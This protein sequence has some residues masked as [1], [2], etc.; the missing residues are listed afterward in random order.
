MYNK[1]KLYHFICLQTPIEFD[2]DPI[3]QL[4]TNI[5]EVE[6]LYDNYPK[7]S[8][9]L[10]YFAR[11]RI[12]KIF[13]EN[14][15]VF[16]IDKKDLSLKLS[17][18]KIDLSELFY[19]QLLIKDEP[20]II[21][22]KYSIDYIKEINNKIFK[23]SKE[24][25]IQDFIA[26]KL[27]LDLIYNYQNDDDNEYD[28]ENE[29]KL[30]DL[31]EKNINILK[32]NLDQNDVIKDLKYDS[33]DDVLEKP[34]DEI[35]VD[36]IN[37]LIKNNYFSDFSKTNKILEKL[38]FETINNTKV[39]HKGIIQAL[40][41]N[42]N[43]LTNYMI[44]ESNDLTEEKV[45]F[46]YFLLKYILKNNYYVFNIPFL[47]KNCDKIVNLNK[48]LNF[49]PESQ[50]SKKI[51]FIVGYYP[52]LK[53]EKKE[54]KEEKKEKKEKEEK[55]EE[56]FLKKIKIKS[57]QSLNEGFLNSSSQEKSSNSKENDISNTQKGEDDINLQ[58]TKSIIM[59]GLIITLMQDKTVEDNSKYKIKEILL[60][61]D[62]FKEYILKNSKE[63]SGEEFLYSLCSYLEN[64]KKDKI[65]KNFKLLLDFIQ[66]I[67]DYISQN[68]LYFKPDIKLD[69]ERPTNNNMFISIDDFTSS[70]DKN[71][72]VYDLTCTSSFKIE[73][74]SKEYKF[75]D[76]NVL[77]NG[78]DEEPFG[79]I[80]LINEL[81]NNDYKIVETE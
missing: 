25:D 56:N 24:T 29:E 39:I 7:E 66:V 55:E 41:K 21:N 73:D 18:N 28:E 4:I 76:F 71:K 32:D 58:L 69:L 10:F 40:D 36:I 72:D 43:Y 30:Q 27:I 19:F 63:K 75:N 59:S 16:N 11:K 17:E 49:N 47:E 26:A 3:P 54:K 52:E 9:K 74:E 37:L 14:D 70:S 20:E 23:Y 81:T 80:H 77:I 65:Y 48:E 12:H 61:E 44:G 57:G 31:K 64:T 8:K 13:Y 45:N 79:F 50:L 2:N 5:K 53:K 68:E 60:K 33:Y 78:I 67:K 62:K 22:Y 46:Y 1:L 6:T 34:I 35:Y 15:Y 42:N 38:N 51:Q